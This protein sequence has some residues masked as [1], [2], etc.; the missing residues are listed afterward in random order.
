M[1]AR[2]SR[3]FVWPQY[4]AAIVTDVEEQR[5][6][7]AKAGI[8]ALQSLFVVSKEPNYVGRIGHFVVTGVARFALT[9]LFSGANNFGDLTSDPL[10]SAAMGFSEGE[11]RTTFGPELERLGREQ[12]GTVDDALHELA[13]WYDGYCFD[14]A[15][16]VPCFNPYPVLVALENGKLTTQEMEGASG[17]NWLGLTP[18]D[19]TQ[20]VVAQ[21]LEIPVV[22]V[23]QVNVNLADLRARRVNV[24]ALL[25]Q[26]G[27][28]T[29]S[30]RKA[31]SAGEAALLECVVPNQYARQ[32][33]VAMLGSAW[34]RLAAPEEAS[35]LVRAVRE[36]DRQRF[37]DILSGVIDN[38][39][40]VIFKKP[41]PEDASVEAKQVV[42]EAPYHVAVW[43]PLFLWLPRDVAHV[44]VEY[45]V[46]GG[47]PDVVVELLPLLPDV[48]E[49]VWVIEV[50]VGVPPEGKL[51]QRSGDVTNAKF[52]GRKVVGAACTVRENDGRRSVEWLWA[53]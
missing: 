14:R 5:W 10:L 26:T 27:L 23:D 9:S 49:E 18:A 4:D 8:E 15:G 24:R 37:Q 21:V 2:V 3:P 39:P 36:R 43:L 47:R 42:R 48:Q 13:R 22:S 34:P 50:G 41:A 19:V 25:L 7:A 51:Q 45:P 16:R 12:G 33:L 11:I 32:S 30:P 6:E 28:L 20:G 29:L 17:T 44:G 52:R 35:D 53:E 40:E 31:P 1:D 46:R 38:I